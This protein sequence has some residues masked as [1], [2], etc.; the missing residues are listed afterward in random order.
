MSGRVQVRT[1][2]TRHEITPYEV[3]AVWW[4]SCEELHQI[5]E[6][7]CKQIIKLNRGEMLKDKK[8]TSRGLESYTPHIRSIA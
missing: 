6:S 7:C 8:Y 4:Y 5:T 1:T 3:A 2:I